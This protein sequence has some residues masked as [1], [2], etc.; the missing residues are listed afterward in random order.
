MKHKIFIVIP[1]FN[2]LEFTKKCLRAVFKQKYRNFQII[3]IDDGS[4]DG[5]FEYVR[6]Y[7]PDVHILFGDGNLWWSR[8]TQMGID[9]ALAAAK[10]S[11]YIFFLNNDC[12]L[13]PNYFD[14]ILRTAKKHHKAIVGSLCISNGRRKKVVEAGVRIDWP[15]GLVYSVAEA[16]STDPKY[17]RNMKVIDK[18]DAL[19]GKG[20]LIPVLVFK[21]IG[22]LNYKKLPHYIA[23]Y[24][25]FNRAKR[26]GFELLVDTK[27]IIKHEWDA[28]GYKSKRSERVGLVEAI[29]L[30]FSKK[31]MANI[32]DWL[33]FLS[34]TCPRE[35][36]TLNYYYTFWRI[37]D[38]A[39][40]VFPLTVFRPVVLIMP[41]VIAICYRTT[42]IL[43][44][45]PGYYWRKLNKK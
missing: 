24:E 15:T 13:G 40:R 43:R 2:R 36:L 30:M 19:P 39:T 8:A 17:Y 14:Q 37:I 28:T 42:V 21:K 25:F 31:S 18:L 29:R 3:L 7:F 41:K 34:L 20:T 22:G 38:G 5:T 1:V 26:N 32:G 44:D 9:Y 23:D 12:F 6:K 45:D 16:I 4:T 11:D 27:A 33:N 35:Y 10:N